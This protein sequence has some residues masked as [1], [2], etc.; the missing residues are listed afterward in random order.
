MSS[1]LD[2]STIIIERI[3]VHD[4][5][6]HKKGELGIEPNYSQEESK[7]SDGL[8]NFFKDKVVQ[9]LSSDR[10]FKICFDEDNT[11]AVP[12]LVG[13]M[14]KQSASNF[15][16]Q[17]K[18]IAKA[19]F[20]NQ[21]GSNASGILVLI[22]GKVNT[23]NACMV[24]KL[25]RD[26]GAQLTLDPKTRSYNIAEVENLMLTQKTKIFKVAMFINR[27]DF[28]AKYDGLIMDYQIDI[29]EK[30]DVMTWF[31]DKFL[32]CVAFEDPR[33][34][35]KKFYDYTR[36]F[37]ETVEDAIDRAKY[38]QDLNSYVQMNSN[39]LNP[40]EFAEHYLRTTEHRNNYRNYLKTKKFRFS[41][42]PKDTSQIQR[43]IKKIVMTFEN[44]ISIS[45]EK[46][47][48]DKKVK[49]QNMNDGQVKAEITSRIRKVA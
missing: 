30:K 32:G 26:K 21:V 47:T 15:V 7:L 10:A 44:G 31:M 13:E 42:F 46:G 24:L 25:E 23:F 45:G 29:A 19:L 4:I 9:A 11:S 41:S 2:T 38:I 34:T 49:F 6:K 33:I 40:K 3:I 27:N 43:K 22:F 18:E 14:I 35:T 39:S 16:L 48:F 8:R 1:K 5:P 17:T 37:I 28:K 20:D 12:W 36:A